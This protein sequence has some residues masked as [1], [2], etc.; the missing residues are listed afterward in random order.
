[1]KIEET[2]IELFEDLSIS[3]VMAIHNGKPIAQIRLLKKYAKDSLNSFLA[4]LAGGGPSEEQAIIYQRS[5]SSVEELYELSPA[6]GDSFSYVFLLLSR[7]MHQ[8][9]T[10]GVC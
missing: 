7:F 9:E 2:E 3:L 6:L 4:S 8:T 5:F 1:M 10:S